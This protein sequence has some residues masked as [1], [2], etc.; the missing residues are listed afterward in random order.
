MA[1]DDGIKTPIVRQ[2]AWVS[3]ISQLVVMCTI[4]A[5]MYVLNAPVPILTG[6]L[7]YLHSLRRLLPAAHRRGVALFKKQGFTAAI[8]EFERSYES[9][10]HHKWI[11]D[12]RDLTLLSSSR[13]S[14]HEM[15]LLNIAFCHGQ[16]GTERKQK[17]T[18]NGPWM[19]SRIAKWQ[20]H[21]SGCLNVWKEL[22]NK[23]IQVTSNSSAAA[24]ACARSGSFGGRSTSF[25]G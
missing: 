9:F 5:V 4:F 8:L 7:V 14:Y 6:A 20:R 11:D 18:T 13:I 21:P 2:I 12:F 1:I 3:V 15:A 17:S 10:T 23:Q 22:P 25:E 24:S 19:S 16:G